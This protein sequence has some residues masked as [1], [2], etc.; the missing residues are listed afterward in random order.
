MCPVCRRARFRDSV[1]GTLRA[2]TEAGAGSGLVGFTGGEDALGGGDGVPEFDGKLKGVAGDELQGAEQGDGVQVVEEAE[3]GDAEE[4]ALHLP[5]SV[6]DDGTEASLESFDDGTGVHALRDGDGGG[7]GGGS[8]GS[9][10]GEA[11]REESGAGHGGT[12]FGVFDEHFAAFDEIATSLACDVVER[13]TET[14]DEGDG[15]SVGAFAF[16]CDLA[17]LAEVEVV[18]RVF[19]G[20]HGSPG[21]V[22]DAEIGESWG[23]H[24]GF[25]GA[26]DEHVDA[27]GVDVEVGGAEAG[28]GV[29]DEQ[30]FG[31]GGAE[32]LCDGLDAVAD[33]GGGFRGLDEDGAVVGAERSTDL[34]RIEGVTVGSGEEIDLAAKGLGESDPA[35]AEFAGREDEDAVAGRGEI[36]D[37]GFHGAGSGA[38]EDDDV[39]LGADEQLQLGQHF[40]VES[41]KLRGAVMDVC[42][43][44]GK[45]SGRQQ[46]GGTGSVETS[47]T[48]HGGVSGE[49]KVR[50]SAKAR[51]NHRIH[52]NVINVNRSVVGQSEFFGC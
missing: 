1:A 31:C 19:A 28:D 50:A 12:G 42:R 44:H 32:G 7:G 24:D 33:G 25:L 9:K 39:V 37:G 35:L 10:E 40:R 16:G 27:P 6:G 3:M 49:M 51:C 45:L 52:K 4:L 18:A 26:S 47:F 5:L 11:Q 38:G 48:E 2:A 43:G 41:T 13:G 21:A 14:G 29:D 46:G 22:A 34:S 15:R 30:G 17:L 20:L 36:T 8:V 23:N